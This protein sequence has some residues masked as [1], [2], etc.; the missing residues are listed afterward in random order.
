MNL[1]I[2]EALYKAVVQMREATLIPQKEAMLILGEVLGKDMTWLVAHENDEVQIDEHFFDLVA[3]RANNEPL[4]YILGR[5]SFYGKEF[6]VDKRV[7]IP[8]PETELLVDK[9]LELARDIQ[10]P[11][12]VEIGCGSGI[13]SIMLSLLFPKARM[14]AVDISQDALHVA[15][16]NAKKFGVEEKINF[17]L[18]SY[19]DGVEEK[20]DILVSNPPYIAQNEP[21]H[22]GLSYEP[23]L[24]LYGGVV[25][26]EMLKHIIDLFKERAIGAL[27]CEM[28]YDQ[29]ASILKYASDKGFEAEFYK[30]LADLDRG[31][32][33]RSQK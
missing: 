16:M 12:I 26:D 30:D 11:H 3:R 24:A 7:L 4:E 22:V 8:R 19:L 15:M 5:A 23:S 6:L 2:K 27:V 32:W 13:I 18:G 21:L 28:G 10:T 1:V 29:R 9:V 25:G 31:F 20:I 17:V 33:I 14:T